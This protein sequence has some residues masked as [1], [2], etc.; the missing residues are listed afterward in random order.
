MHARNWVLIIYLLD[1]NIVSEVWKVR[2]NPKVKQFLTQI[3]LSQSYLAILTITELKFGIEL[4]E[5]SK[6]KQYFQ[7][8]FQQTLETYREQI[9]S[10]DISMAN[11]YAQMAAQQK[12]A[13][14]I[15]PIFDLWIAATAKSNNLTLVTR[16]SK[17]YLGLDIKLVNPF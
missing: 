13:G 4:L 2:P 10:P 15:K 12:K 3:P 7:Q 1:T 14:T 6:K 16:N 5:T 11:A 17:D 9:I 8:A